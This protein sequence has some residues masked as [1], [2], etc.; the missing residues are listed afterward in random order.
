MIKFFIN[1][2]NVYRWLDLMAYISYTI[3]AVKKITVL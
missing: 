3:D 1:K 2:N